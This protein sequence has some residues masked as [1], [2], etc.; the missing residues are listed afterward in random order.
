MSRTSLYS[1]VAAIQAVREAGL[2]DGDLQR[3]GSGVVI[4]CGLGSAET[5]VENAQKLIE[6][7]SPR[8]I[9]SHG[10]D[11]TMASTCAAKAVH[12]NNGFM[13]MGS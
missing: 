2:T 12:A 8:R 7:G 6:Q 11:R 3:D 5:I 9:G 13:A 10:V 4:G 1:T